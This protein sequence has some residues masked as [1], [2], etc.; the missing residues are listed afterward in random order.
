VLLS[1]IYDDYLVA[2]LVDSEPGYLELFEPLLW[3]RF[4]LGH[5]V[6][7]EILLLAGCCYSKLPLCYHVSHQ[8]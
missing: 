2:K 3:V 6:H 8:V 5:I 7:K 1:P 4:F